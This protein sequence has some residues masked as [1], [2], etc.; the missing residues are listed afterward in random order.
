M[1][2]DRDSRS[3]SLLYDHMGWLARY[4]KLACAYSEGTTIMHTVEV[5]IN[6]FLFLLACRTHT[7]MNFYGMRF[8]K[9]KVTFRDERKKDTVNSRDKVPLP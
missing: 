7:S 5:I 9:C 2:K 3:H 6:G 1:R 4:R 8:T